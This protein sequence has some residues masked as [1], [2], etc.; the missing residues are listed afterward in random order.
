MSILTRAL[1][2][3][4]A[5][6]CGFVAVP[7]AIGFGARPRAEAAPAN[8]RR[9]A[10]SCILTPQAVEGPFYFDPRLNRGDITEGHAGAPLAIR[11][12]VIEAQ[13]CAPLAGARLDIWHANAS[14]IYSG[15]SSQG[16]DRETDAAGQTFLRGSQVV[17]ERGEATFRTV[18]PGWYEGRTTHIHFK[19]FVDD[20]TLLTGQMY[21]PDALS[22]YIYANVNPYKMRTRKRGIFN[23]N[24]GLARMDK[25]HGGFCDIKEE[26]DH[27]LAT[28]IIAASLSGATPADGADMPPPPP[29]FGPPRQ[30]AQRAPGIIVP[31]VDLSNQ[32]QG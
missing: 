4:R 27:Y 30:P 6:L 23:S 18:Y 13:R 7:A 25:G 15:Y 14:G 29:G 31:G 22:E 20:R 3:R 12:V 21:F 19:V 10:P 9:I 2:T 8:A 26:A 1:A 16:D 11:F 24:D 32:R 17:D 5:A 28:L